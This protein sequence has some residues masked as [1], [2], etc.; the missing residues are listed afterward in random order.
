[1]VYAWACRQPRKSRSARA[2]VPACVFCLHSSLFQR[3]RARGR[4]CACDDVPADYVPALRGFA[5]GALLHARVPSHTH[6]R[7]THAH[8]HT[9][10][11][12]RRWVLK[13]RRWTSPRGAF[14]PFLCVCAWV[15]VGVGACGCAR[16]MHTIAVMYVMY[17]LHV[18]CAGDACACILALA[19]C[20]CVRA[21]S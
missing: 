21:C 13:R 10:R 17:V 19:L 16:G 6:T 3:E 1:M 5:F 12:G 8:T 15:R 18:L 7:R 4:A 11:T 9:H 14:L 2:G 20:V